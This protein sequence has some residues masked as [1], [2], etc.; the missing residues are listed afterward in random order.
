MDTILTTGTPWEFIDPGSFEE[1]KIPKCADQF[2]RLLDAIRERYCCLPQPGH[3]LQ[4]LHLQLELIDNFRQRLVQLHNSTVNNVSTTKILNVIN[5]LNSVLREWGENVHYLHLHAALVGPNAEEINSVFDKPVEELE[6]WQRKLVKELSLKIVDDIKARS[7]PYRHDGWVTMSE[8]NSKEPFILSFTAGEMFQIMV[9][10]LHN[11]EMELSTNLFN[12]TLRLISSSLDSF[13]IDSMVMNTKFSL[14][15]AVQF[16]FDMCRNLFA[17]FGQYS[18]RP[19]L[20][21]KK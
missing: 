17:L 9:T 14:G 20:L 7:M 8:Q 10:N 5:Y 3:Q 11:L 12:V 21:F 6:H 13:F 4:F 2:I 15:G 1:L 19:E 18:R 16:Q